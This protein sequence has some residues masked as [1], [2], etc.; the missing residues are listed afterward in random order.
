MENNH[1]LNRK[2]A[3]GAATRESCLTAAIRVFAERGYHRASMDEIAHAAGVTTGALYWHF[4][5]KE[6]FLVE[7]LRHY[8]R[9]ANPG[10]YDT[11]APAERADE[12]I[13]SYV[14]G[15]ARIDAEFPWP[16]ALTMMVMMDM[17]NL[18]RPEFTSFIREILSW[19]R[20]LYR[21]LIEYG[22]RSGIFRADCD[23]AAIANVLG[24]VRTGT[25]ARF[26]ALPDEVDL[27]EETLSSVR[28]IL[29]AIMAP[30]KKLSDRFGEHSI[31]R[32]SATRS[33]PMRKEVR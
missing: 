21:G 8:Y 31:R 29:S 2:K 12:L 3:K 22:Q 1:Q 13:L 18:R 19:N 4:S 15:H 6:D 32:E 20:V 27:H 33:T 16:T 11:S 28:A 23:A 17:R 14:D 7:V 5:G 30:G 10:L 25:F 24:T 26:S 9:T